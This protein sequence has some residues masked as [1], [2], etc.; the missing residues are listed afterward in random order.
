MG[1]SEGN[2]NLI[3]FFQIFAIDFAFIL[4]QQLHY[5]IFGVKNN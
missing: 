5:D 4:H 3:S 2:E 1:S